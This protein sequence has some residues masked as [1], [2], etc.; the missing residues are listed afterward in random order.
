[1][2]AYL[3]ASKRSPSEVSIP[4]MTSWAAARTGLMASVAL[5]VRKSWRGM[6]VV[7]SL[8]QRELEVLEHDAN[9]IAV[10]VGRG[11]PP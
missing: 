7:I 6:R 5:S 2:G 8:L 4:A 10:G 3:N 11:G 1:M 9:V